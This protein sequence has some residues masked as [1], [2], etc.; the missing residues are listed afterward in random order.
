MK[1]GV[2]EDIMKLELS[3]M[4]RTILEGVVEDMKTELS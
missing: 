4:K 1:K 2:I 3:W